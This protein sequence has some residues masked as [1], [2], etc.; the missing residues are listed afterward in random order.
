MATVSMTGMSHKKRRIRNLPI[1]YLVN[2]QK[3]LADCRED[4]LLPATQV[5]NL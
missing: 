1:I 3:S 2:K 5:P 4:M